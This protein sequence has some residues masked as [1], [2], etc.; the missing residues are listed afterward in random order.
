[1]YSST[2]SIFLASLIFC[3]Q[4]H[5]VIE[6]YGNNTEVAEAANNLAVALNTFVNGKFLS[7]HNIVKLL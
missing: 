2:F 6:E 5:P 7:H 3:V 1:M 4:G